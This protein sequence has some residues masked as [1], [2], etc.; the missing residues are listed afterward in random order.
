MSTKKY[1]KDFRGWVFGKS[2]PAYKKTEYKKLIRNHYSTLYKYM[3]QFGNYLKILMNYSVVNKIIMILLLGRKRCKSIIESTD[4][5]DFVTINE[6]NKILAFKGF[7]KHY[8]KYLKRKTHF[9]I[10]IGQKIVP[11]DIEKEFTP[12]DG[13]TILKNNA[14]PKFAEFLYL[15]TAEYIILHNYIWASGL[16]VKEIKSIDT[17]V[18]NFIK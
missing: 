15:I 17:W 1:R 7:K 11:I 8:L 18:L 14:I 6:I 16:K 4:R 10:S 2:K 3:S 5:R 13:K 9:S 12:P